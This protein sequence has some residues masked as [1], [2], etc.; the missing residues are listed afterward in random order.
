MCVFL[1]FRHF[2]S[3]N[4][5]IIRDCNG[6]IAL[7]T[8]RRKKMMVMIMIYII[9]TTF[10]V[11]RTHAL[12]YIDG[13]DDRGWG[14]TITLMSSFMQITFLHRIRIFHQNIYFRSSPAP[15]C[16]HRFCHFFLTSSSC[17]I[18][19]SHWQFGTSFISLRAPLWSATLYLFFIFSFFFEHR[20]HSTAHPTC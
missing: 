4:L 17:Y 9:N 1:S 11:Y 20:H 5:F 2:I 8:F 15:L 12:A 19:H 16:C 3:L 14:Q 6:A 7:Y 18:P 10:S 13:V